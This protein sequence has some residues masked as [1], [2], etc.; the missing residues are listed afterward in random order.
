MENLNEF[1]KEASSVFNPN[2]D[3]NICETTVNNFIFGDNIFEG[4]ERENIRTT[5]NKIKNIDSDEVNHF[6]D[7]NIDIHFTLS[8]PQL[9]YL[10]ALRKMLGYR[11]CMIQKRSDITRTLENRYLL[12]IDGVIYLLFTTD[13]PDVIY[14]ISTRSQ[15]IDGEKYRN[16][17]ELEMDDNNYELKASELDDTTEA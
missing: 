16:I 17:L 4:E 3:E 2:S 6:F 9:T 15:I 8:E 13:N 12:Y 7:D 5:I 1:M 11:F 14:G 10:C